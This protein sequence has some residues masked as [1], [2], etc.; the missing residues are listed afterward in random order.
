MATAYSAGKFKQVERASKAFPYLMYDAVNDGRT[1]PQHRA[2]DNLVLRWDDPWWKTHYPPNGW[3][4]RCSVIPLSQRGLD[5]RGLKGPDAAP[6]TETYEW[7]N[8]RTGEVMEVPAGIDPGWAYHPGLVTR[9]AETL[10]TL[11][12]KLEAVPADF[13]NAALKDIVQSPLFIDWLKDPQ[14]AF[15]V[16]R[17]KDEAALAIGAERKIA[18]LSAESLDHIHVRHPEITP[19]DLAVLPLMGESPTVIVQVKDNKLIIVRAGEKAYWAVVKAATGGG[20]EAFL[21]TFRKTRAQDVEN[22]IKTGKV[23]YGEWK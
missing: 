2:W 16:M 9:N 13:A 5:R 19:E 15:P 10:Q 1:R 17:I 14:G 8:P 22:L 18:V 6:P 7:T 4:C 21:T 12:D 3:N 23:I 20:R 11:A